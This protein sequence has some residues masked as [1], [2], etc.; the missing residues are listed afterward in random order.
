VNFIKPWFLGRL[1]REKVLVLALLLVGAL[2]WLS[3]ASKALTANMRAFRMAEASLAEQAIWL[4][5]RQAIED[6]A[7]A[8]AANLDASKTY[9]ATYLVA[10]VTGMA[11]RAG[12]AVNTE[13][14]RT[15][16]S[17]QFAI[18]TVQVTTRKAD[19]ASLLRFYQELSSKAPYLGLEQV[20]VQ[21]D[22]GNPGMVNVNMQIASVELLS[23]A[24]DK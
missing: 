20:S 10:E 9:N 24:A 15:Q 19:L 6:A 17:P 4:D 13:A 2:I 18:H 11:K 22:R 21:G 1:L 8:A 16:R 3:S 12:L 5:N 23:A 14:P 7:K